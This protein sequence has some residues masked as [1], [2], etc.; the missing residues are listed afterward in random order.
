MPAEFDLGAPL[1]SVDLSLNFIAEISYRISFLS[2]VTHLDLSKNNIARLHPGTTTASFDQPPSCCNTSPSVWRSLLAL[3]VP[4]RPPPSTLDPLTAT[5]QPRLVFQCPLA[6][7][8]AHRLQPD[9]SEHP[10]VQASTLRFSPASGDQRW[11]ASGRFAVSSFSLRDC[12]HLSGMQR[13]RSF[14]SLVAQVLSSP[15][16]PSLNPFNLFQPSPSTNF[17]RS[18]DN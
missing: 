7:A 4:C 13:M 6:V 2:S 12:H 1:I 16:N 8:A 5:F 3:Q 10:A 11:Y 14:I 15:L 17:D 18:T 9:A